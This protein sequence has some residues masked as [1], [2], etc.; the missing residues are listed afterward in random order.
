MLWAI[1]QILVNARIVG[2][3][4]DIVRI[5]HAEQTINLGLTQLACRAFGSPSSSSGAAVLYVSTVCGFEA[6]SAENRTQ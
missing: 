4:L 1:R 6:R 5:P 2:C 3:H